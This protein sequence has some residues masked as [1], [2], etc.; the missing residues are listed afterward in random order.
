MEEEGLSIDLVT[1]QHLLKA[2]LSPPE[3]DV[4]FDQLRVILFETL[5]SK[6]RTWQRISQELLQPEQ[7][8]PL[9]QLMYYSTY[10]DWDTTTLGPPLGW[11]PT[12]EIARQSNLGRLL[13]RKGQ[14]ILGEKYRSPTESLPELQR[15]SAEYPEKYFPLVWNTQSL[16][17]HQQPRCFLDTSNEA[18]PGGVW[19]PGASLNVAESC[20]TTKGSKNDSS[21]AILYRN[22]GEDGS[23][24]SKVTLSQLRANASRV[25]NALDA[26]GFK[27]GDAIAIDMPMNVH[28]VTVYLGIILAGCIAACI[29]DSFVANEI[30]VRIRISKSKAIFTQ[31]II[32]RGGKELPLYSR[33]VEA[34]APLVIVIPSDGKSSCLRLRGGDMVWREFVTR[35]EHVS[36]PD[37]YKAV[38][39]SIDSHTNILFSSGTTGEPKAI[40]WTQHA[41]LRCAADAWAHLDAREGDII[42]WPTNL[43]WVVGHLVLYAA[44][45]NGATLALF[46]GSPLDQEF[47]KFV[48]DANI[49][50][51]GTVPSL[52]KTWKT[53]G[54]MANL[55]WSRIRIFSSTGESSSVDDDLWLSARGGYKPVLECCGGT[56]LGSMYLA[57]SLVQPQ[58]F[59][60]FSTLGMTIKAF[61]LDYSSNSYPLRRH[62]DIFQRFHG[63]FYKAYG[64]SDD[65]MNLGGIKAS[66][67]EIEQICNKAHDSVQETAAVAVQPPGGGPDEL[68]IAAVLKPGF[69]LSTKELQKFFHS[70]VVSNLNPLFKVKAVVVF[71]EFPRTPSNKLLRRVLRVECA[72]IVNSKQRSRL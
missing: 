50:I 32:R 23:P 48:Q 14:D 44:F 19:V 41:P 66:A 13:E 8:F 49:S 53:S 51:L 25:A 9:H 2:G 7:P 29:P 55:D 62:G 22:E 43:G 20:L 71:P 26:L 60:T 52:V 63:A 46:N 65:T 61:I 12:P 47:G 16:V 35:A 30:A 37:E 58:A 1:K 70:S 67:V 40:P 5:Q 18:D 10:R 15:W 39:Q 34:R 27:R 17:F 64:R 3:A 56:E 57:G 36:R 59:A 45:L 6:P 42:C 11:I 54:C 69:N 68:L 33:V 24:V 28:A 38:V 31:D 72:K 21:I 4:F